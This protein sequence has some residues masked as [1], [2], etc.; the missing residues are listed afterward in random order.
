MH[1]VIQLSSSSHTVLKTIKLTNYEFYNANKY[2]YLPYIMHY[3]AYKRTE[4]YSIAPIIWPSLIRTSRIIHTIVLY[5]CHWP[6]MLNCPFNSHAWLI[7][8]NFPRIFSANYPDYTVQ[9]GIDVW[10]KTWLV[11]ESYLCGC[12]RFVWFSFR[13]FFNVNLVF[14]IG[15]WIYFTHLKFNKPISWRWKF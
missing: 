3:K 9:V 5:T 11:S 7:S 2:I 1:L 15:S 4:R 13:C 12:G 6:S 8:S 10:N 14:N